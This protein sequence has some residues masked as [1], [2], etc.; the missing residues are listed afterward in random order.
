LE[1]EGFLRPPQRSRFK[2]EPR[3][4]WREDGPPNRKDA[5]REKIGGGNSLRGVTA[6]IIKGFQP[7][8]PILGRKRGGN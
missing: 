8:W 2:M 6:P 3:V 4:S 7:T 1:T 5:R